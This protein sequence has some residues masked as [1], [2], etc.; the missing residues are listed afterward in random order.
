MEYYD[1]T[2]YSLILT[3][4]LWHKIRAM[5]KISV[6]RKRQT[7]TSFVENKEVKLA[8]MFKREIVHE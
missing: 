5:N 7:F 3:F 6:E 8:R 4:I 1:T 2:V